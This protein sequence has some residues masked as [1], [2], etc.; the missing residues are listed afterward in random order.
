M[1]GQSPAVQQCRAAQPTNSG[2]CTYLQRRQGVATH[3]RDGFH[4][5][6]GCRRGRRRPVLRRAARGCRSATDGD[7]RDLW[8][9][10]DGR[11]PI[12]HLQQ[13]DGGHRHPFVGRRNRG[14]E[15]VLRPA[16][17]RTSPLPPRL[18]RGQPDNARR[19]APAPGG[20]RAVRARAV[21]D[22]EDDVAAQ[23]RDA[24]RRLSLRASPPAHPVRRR[25]LPGIDHAALR[26]ARLLQPRPARTRAGA[27]GAKP[28]GSFNQ[29][30]YPHHA[31][32]G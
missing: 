32:V 16:R 2:A 13:M 21:A 3:R 12:L 14:C 26:L 28:K 23:L 25:L 4:G 6:K 5:R 22:A 31:H 9:P 19:S 15:G 7:L 29:A 20:A 11:R 1:S 27:R 30:G 10:L 17:L 18:L 24:V 8:L